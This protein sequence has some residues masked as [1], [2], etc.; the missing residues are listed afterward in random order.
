MYHHDIMRSVIREREREMRA[1]ADAIRA[2]RLARR[3][4]DY[5]AERAERVARPIKRRT[6]RQ[7]AAPAR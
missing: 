2:G 7:G 5:W 4:R 3:A 6:S 1:E